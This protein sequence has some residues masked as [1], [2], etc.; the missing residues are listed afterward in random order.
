M[1]SFP[2]ENASLII[3]DFQLDFFKSFKFNNRITLSSYKV[4]EVGQYE[5]INKNFVASVDVASK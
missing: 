2:I 1:Y 3:N 4:F 5:K